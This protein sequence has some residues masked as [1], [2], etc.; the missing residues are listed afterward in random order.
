MVITPTLQ[1]STHTQILVIE[2]AAMDDSEY[3][4]APITG[5]KKR[6]LEEDGTLTEASASKTPKIPNKSKPE[7][8]SVFNPLQH[9]PQLMDSTTT[10]NKILTT[11][12]TTF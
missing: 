8:K 10:H 5:S 6:Q 4:P 7:P 9:Q 11:S 12:Q 2:N 3:T 1:S